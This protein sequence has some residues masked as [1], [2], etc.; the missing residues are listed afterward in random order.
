[1]STHNRKKPPVITLAHTEAWRMLRS[2]SI[3]SRGDGGQDDD[4]YWSFNFNSP[5]SPR[6]VMQAQPKHRLPLRHK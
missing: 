6:L 4:E 1:M 2:S 5:S 3:L